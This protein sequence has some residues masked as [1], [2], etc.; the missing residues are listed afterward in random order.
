MLPGRVFNG[1]ERVPIEWRVAGWTIGR[2]SLVFPA[3]AIVM[4]A[5]GANVT[6]WLGL[7]LAAIPAALWAIYVPMSN[8][9]N[10]DL[11]L[12]EL[13]MLRLMLWS[14]RHRRSGTRIYYD[15]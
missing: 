15:S 2:L 13:T 3:L 9:V 6:L 1:V 11:R 14:L 12:D 4:F 7:V 10:P 5:L 8:R